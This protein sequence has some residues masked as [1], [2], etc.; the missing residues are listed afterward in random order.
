MS[1]GLWGF[2]GAIMNVPESCYVVLHI[3]HGPGGQDLQDGLRIIV[4]DGGQ[5]QLTENIWMERLDKELGQKIQNA[6]E[7]RHYNISDAGYD[8][9]LY[10]FVKRVTESEKTRFEGMS[11]LGAVVA[12]SRLVHPTSTGDRYAARIFRYGDKD[13]PIECVRFYGVSQDVSLIDGRRDWLSAVDGQTLLRLTPWLNK[14][15]HDRV[16]HAY[17]NHESALRSYYLDVKW[18]FVV[19]AFEALLNSGDKNVSAQFKERVAQLA[20]YSKVTLTAD[21]IDKAY[22]LRSKLVHAESFLF[23]LN[24]ILPQS[25]HVPLYTKLETLLRTTLLT[26]LLDETFGNNFRDE[27]SIDGA[28]PVN[29]PVRKSKKVP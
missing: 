18:I 4:E 11:E 23:G 29:F 2:C 20:N 16:H 17:W 21:E 25:D 8:R 15:M 12:L 5:F 10:A 14:K 3:S 19:S 26:C 13:S 6:C 28:W 9:H 27:A 22:Q 24:N 7:P 1:E